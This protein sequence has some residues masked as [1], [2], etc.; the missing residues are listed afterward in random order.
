M[1]ECDVFEAIR[2]TEH[3]HG[4]VIGNRFCCCCRIPFRRAAALE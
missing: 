4:G 1:T 2:A 3:L